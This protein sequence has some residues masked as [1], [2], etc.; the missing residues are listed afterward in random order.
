MTDFVLS[1]RA[2]SFSAALSAIVTALA[3]MGNTV[4]RVLAD[5]KI[6][7]A[8][9]FDLLMSAP[10]VQVVISNAPQAAKDWVVLDDSERAE[11]INQFAVQFDLPTDQVEA[12]IE[13]VLRE[14]GNIYTLTQKL[15][16]S[17][18][19]VY[20]ALKPAADNTPEARNAA[21][22]SRANE[23]IAKHAAKKK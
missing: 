11:I 5:R 21:K 15:V 14:A 9:Y 7:G 2:Q 22:E 1:A 18:K 8:E 12:K 20:A 4:G 13:T 6:Q 3:N 10:N 23:V 16:K 17:I 19:N